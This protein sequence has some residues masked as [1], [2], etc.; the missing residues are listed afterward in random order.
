MAFGD[1]FK[2]LPMADLIG[3]PLTA[4]CDANVR[5]AQSTAEFIAT[6]G[7]DEKNQ[8]RKATFGYTRQVNDEKGNLLPAVP[9]K[10]EVPLL[11]IVQTP[12]LKVNNVNITF[13][14]EIKTH[15]DSKTKSAAEAALKGSGQAGWGPFSVKVE[16]SGSVSTSKENTRSTD[17]SAKYHVEVNAVDSGMPEG[18]AR[19]LDILNQAVTPVP[20]TTNPTTP[21]TP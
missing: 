3:A 2:G 4:A 16:V 19:V 18:L 14:M 9:M 7:F 1:D 6:I 12:N 15:E 11:A 13:D 8:V 20:T 21:T 5:L 17:K 10:I